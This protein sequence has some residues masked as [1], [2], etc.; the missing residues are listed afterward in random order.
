MTRF[1]MHVLLQSDQRLPQQR[2]PTL[3]RN[4]RQPAVFVSRRVVFCLPIFMKGWGPPGRQAVPSLAGRLCLFT[5]H[6][7]LT[8]VSIRLCPI[9]CAVK[10]SSGRRAGKDR[11]GS[12]PIH[13]LSI[14]TGTFTRARDR[15][16]PWHHQN[17]QQHQCKC[18]RGP[19]SSCLGSFSLL[20]GPA[21]GVGHGPAQPLACAHTYVD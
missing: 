18:L 2:L 5:L 14:S 19:V 16:Q 12:H 6:A 13:P 3:A 15:V 8:G 4:L 1:F 11:L 9:G 20:E 10:S 17:Q 7:E 21:S